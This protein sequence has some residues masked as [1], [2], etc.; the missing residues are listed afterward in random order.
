MA[1]RMDLSTKTMALQ[2]PEG[3]RERHPID[4]AMGSPSSTRWRVKGYEHRLSTHDYDGPLVI[5]THYYSEN[6]ALA[7]RGL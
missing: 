3:W 4:G 1:S 7:Q 6:S 2:T 5:T